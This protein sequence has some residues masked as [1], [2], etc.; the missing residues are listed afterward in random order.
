MKCVVIINN[1]QKGA[2]LKMTP[3]DCIVSQEQIDRN[4]HKIVYD[5]QSERQ[6]QFIE[7]VFAKKLIYVE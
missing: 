4:H 6:K 5:I 3:T 1:Y 2:M 7:K